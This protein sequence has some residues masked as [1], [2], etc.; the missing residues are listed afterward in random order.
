MQTDQTLNSGK[1]TVL[2]PRKALNKA[3]LKVKPI[4]SQIEG[5]KQHLIQLLDRT[6]DTESEEFHK[7]RNDDLNPEE[8]FLN[9][10]PEISNHLKG[11]R[12]KA[13]KRADKGDYYWELRACDYYDKFLEPK[14]MYQV[15]QVKPCFVFDYEGMFCNNS[16]WIIPSDDKVLLAILNS[17]LGWWLI[18]KYCTK[19]QNGYQLIWDYLGQIPII[20]GPLKAREEI[21]EKVNQ[22]LEIKKEQHLENTSFLEAEIDQLVYQLY[23]M[24]EDEVALVENS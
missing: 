4:R 24:T 8:W 11:Y 9:T 16:M 22:L 7:K 19:I 2:K 20:S 5:F 12:E 10:F 15:F 23:G 21:R 1:I 6:N 18:S 3:F 13:E 17:K 14:I